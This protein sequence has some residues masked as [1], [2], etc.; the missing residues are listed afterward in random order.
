M[1]VLIAALSAWIVAQTGVGPVSPP[2]VEFVTPRHMTEIAFGP[3]SDSFSRLRA[4]YSQHV[5]TIYLRSNWSPDK[6]DDRSE[7]VHELVHHFQNVHNL[8]YACNAAREALAYELQLEWL[9]QQGVRN[10]YDF[11]DSDPFTIVMVSV[12]RDTAD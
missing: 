12:C 10:P 5:S 4:L 2:R 9:R 1:D 7:L 8:P 6:L 3:G 11:L